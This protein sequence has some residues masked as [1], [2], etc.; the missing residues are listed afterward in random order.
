[1]ST[2]FWLTSDRP[3]Q[4]PAAPADRL[5]VRQYGHGR[6]IL[7]ALHGF[8][9]SGERM[10][11]LGLHLADIFTTL[12]PDLPYHGKTEWFSD[13][14]SKQDLIGLLQQ[15]LDRYPDRPVFLMGHSLG[16][17]YLSACLEGLQHPDLRDLA[18]VAPDGA[19]GRYTNWIDTLPSTLVKPLARISERPRTILRLSRWLSKRGIINRYSADYLKYSLND[20]FFRRRLAGTLRSVLTFP[21][22]PEDFECA[23][24]AKHI[25]CTVFVGDKDPLL[26]HDRLSRMYEPLPSV[27]LHHY[28]GSHWL[29]QS[30]L[31]K[32]Y[33][34][35]LAAALP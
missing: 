9:R 30:I 18:L 17:R 24:T 35:S 16:G 25:H 21:P 34:N 20:R 8:G 26:H 7:L 15:L 31:A 1:M 11:R 28:T 19:G 5:Y 3:K 6:A 27:D 22:R 2:H 4:D 29:P 10:Q 23:L 33:R 32:Y 13:R 12:A 14:Y